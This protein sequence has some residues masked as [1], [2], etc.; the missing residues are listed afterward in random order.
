VL[1]VGAGVLDPL[2]ERDSE[3]TLGDEAVW[4]AAGQSPA[5]RVPTDSGYGSR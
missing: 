3:P 2:A 4:D 5:F 1:E